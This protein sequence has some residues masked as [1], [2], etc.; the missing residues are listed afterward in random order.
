MVTL[1]A[2][3]LLSILVVSVSGC[4]LFFEGSCLNYGYVVY[5]EILYRLARG[6]RDQA[7]PGVGDVIMT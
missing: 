2:I 3:G 1:F 4:I 6:A 5:F 7:G